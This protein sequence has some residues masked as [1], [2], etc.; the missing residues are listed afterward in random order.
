MA[1]AT[2]AP[3]LNREWGHQE[4]GHLTYESGLSLDKGLQLRNR[5]YEDGDLIT[6][7]LPKFGLDSLPNLAE[8]K[9]HQP[10]KSRPPLCL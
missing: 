5:T 9:C 2:Q 3:L 6:E 8:V 7:G 10:R 1:K 4:A